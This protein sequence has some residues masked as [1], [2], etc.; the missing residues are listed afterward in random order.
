M[1]ELLVILFSAILTNN[2][3]LSR[4]MGICPFLGVSNKTKSAVGMGIA[5]IVV[6]TISTIVTYP[7][8]TLILVPNGLS[9]LNTIIFILVIA[10]FV[11]L[12]EMF[13]KKFIPPLYSA[14]GIYLP[15]I[16]TNCA[17]LGITRINIEDFSGMAQFGHA[18]VNA[19]GAGLG[20]LIAMVIFSGVRTRLNCVKIPKS[21]QGLPITLVAAAIVAISF[22]GFSGVIDGI[23]AAAESG[24]PFFLK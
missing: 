1:K 2:V 4:F 3:V 14:L 7:I 10:S 6:M 15:L 17:V 21:F 13:L 9:F 18:I 12:L 23:F 19:V 8:S 22:M 11:Q 20:F 24:I 5:V 16:T